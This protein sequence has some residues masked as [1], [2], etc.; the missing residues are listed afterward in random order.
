MRN[1]VGETTNAGPGAW[2]LDV[3]SGTGAN[4]ALI[5]QR[6][7]RAGELVGVDVTPKLL[8]SQAS[9]MSTEPQRVHESI[10][11]RCGFRR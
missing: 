7:G 10:D 11:A 4:F 3:V 5:E 9:C 1:S 6:V 8:R 2:L